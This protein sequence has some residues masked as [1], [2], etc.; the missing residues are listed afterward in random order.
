MHYVPRSGAFSKVA[1]SA[2]NTPLPPGAFKG[3]DTNAKRFH[4]DYVLVYRNQKLAVV[5][6]K[7][8]QRQ[9]TEGVAQAKD[10]AGRLAIRFTYATNGQGIYAVD[11]ESGHE[12]LC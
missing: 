8:A 12:G 1:A 6:A 11:M 3:R 10:Y 9:L 5:E 4:A 2:A 7:A